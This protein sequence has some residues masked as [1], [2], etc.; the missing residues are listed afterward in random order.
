MKLVIDASIGIKWF[1]PENES[2]LEVAL[3]LRENILNNKNNVLIPNLFLYEIFNAL[4]LNTSF[5]KDE[6]N[7]ALNTI[8]LMEL[9]II[10]SDKGL[11]ERTL[12]ISYDYRITY[13]DSLYIASAEAYNSFLITE[14][15]E[16]LSL[17]NKFNFVKSQK[18]ISIIL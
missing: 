15:K 10:N 12:S 1:K 9:E 5:T 6:L 11:L 2:N 13:Y 4:L 3:I 17:R 8:Y 16:I 18:E 14:D 7:D